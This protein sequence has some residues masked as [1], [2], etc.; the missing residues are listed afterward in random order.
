MQM[1]EIIWSEQWA[2]T[3]LVALGPIYRAQR[4][5]RS[6]VEFLLP[7]YFVHLH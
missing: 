1:N 2:G 3:L 4:D 7:D 5:E 6:D